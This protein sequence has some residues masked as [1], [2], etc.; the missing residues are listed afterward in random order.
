MQQIKKV[1]F[2]IQQYCKNGIKLINEFVSQAEAFRKTKVSQSKISEVCNGNRL[3]AGGF[4]WKK[5]IKI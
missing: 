1:L 2:S 3:T 4:F 5:T